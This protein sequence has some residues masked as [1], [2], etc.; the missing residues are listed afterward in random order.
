M[1]YL[2]TEAVFIKVNREDAECAGEAQSAR[3]K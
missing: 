2:I 3:P 1:D